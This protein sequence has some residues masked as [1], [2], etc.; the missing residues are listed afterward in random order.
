MESEIKDLKEQVLILQKTLD[1]FYEDFRSDRRARGEM[2]ITLKGV[3]TKT[4]MA[5]EDIADQHSETRRIVEDGIED[6]IKPI[7][8]KIN[9]LVASKN[10]VVHY[11]KD[12][13]KKPFW[14]FWKRG[15]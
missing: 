2:E 10:A 15:D 14:K 6:A 11:I 13:R 8:K 1:R 9:K 12:E 7:E 4:D 5:R 3:E